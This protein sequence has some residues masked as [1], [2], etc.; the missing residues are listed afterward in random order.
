MDNKYINE[1]KYQINNKKVKKVSKLLLIFGLVIL[2][3]GLVC[4]VLSFLNFKTSAS[5]SINCLNN[6][7][8]PISGMF[9]SFGMFAIGGFF[10][11][12]GSGLLMFGGVLT[13]TA[14]RREISAYTATQAMPVFK[15]SVEEVTPTMS[16]ASG[17]IAKDVT[18]GVKEGL[19]EE[20]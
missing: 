13:L 11:F 17:T 7:C 5:E 18:K 2:I 20:K 4:M 19:K 8:D 3:I 10:I 9:N 15:E 14:H 6:N 1:E 16:K 12:I